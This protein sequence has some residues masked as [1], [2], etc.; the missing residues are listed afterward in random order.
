MPTSQ[1]PRLTALAPMLAVSNVLE[2]VAYYRDRLG[3]SVIFVAESDDLAT[4]GVVCRDNLAVHFFEVTGSDP[5]QVTAGISIT[6]NDVDA[7]YR[8]LQG[9]GA[10]AADFPR[11]LDNIREHPPEDKVY[12]MRDLIFVDPNGYTLVWGHPLS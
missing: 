8:E 2:T 3:F 9:R 4:Y 11:H 6:V 7:L 12:G 5:A 10:F 1:T